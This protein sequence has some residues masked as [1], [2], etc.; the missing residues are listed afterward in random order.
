MTFPEPDSR[1]VRNCRQVAALYTSIP[2]HLA[3]GIW[4]LAS[5]IWHLA[6]GIW[7]LASGIWHLASGIWHL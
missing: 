4:H 5:G 6:S 1:P 3:S 7:H 2:L